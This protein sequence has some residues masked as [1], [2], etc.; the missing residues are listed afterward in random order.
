MGQECRGREAK[1]KDASVFPAENRG[2]LGESGGMTAV[3]KDKGRD[4]SACEEL[5]L[6]QRPGL[7]R[8]VNEQPPAAGPV[9]GC[10][11]KAAAR[12]QSKTEGTPSLS[13]EK[14]TLDR[15]YR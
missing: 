2:G 14:A 13:Q 12:L 10:S 6:Q 9:P 5:I 8:G 4:D 1:Q 3:V 15:I 7:P 11:L